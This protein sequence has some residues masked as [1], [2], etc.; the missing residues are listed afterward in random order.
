M[1]SRT[2]VYWRHRLLCFVPSISVLFMVAKKWGGLCESYQWY[3]IEHRTQCLN[4]EIPKRIYSSIIYFCIP[5]HI[6]LL[7]TFAFYFSSMPLH[8]SITPLAINTLI[9]FSISSI[10]IM[11]KLSCRKNVHYHHRSFL[12]IVNDSLALFW[13]VHGLHIPLFHWNS[14]FK[15]YY[16]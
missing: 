16:S 3:A 12:F 1:D 6:W 5:H 15:C 14:N 7:F 11:S 2:A 8:L 9:S 10:R 13:W 4:N